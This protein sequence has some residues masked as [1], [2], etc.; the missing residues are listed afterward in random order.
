[1]PADI[2]IF[3]KVALDRLSSPDQID[4]L[5]NVTSSR[6]WLALVAVSSLLA[7]ATAWG[8][9]GSVTTKVDGQG[10]VIRSGGV[11]DIVSLGAGQVIEVRAITGGHVHTGDLIAMVAQPALLDHIHAAE[12]QIHDLEAQQREVASAHASSSR[13]ELASIEQER[14]SAERSIRDLEAEAKLV[15]DEIAVD[16]ELLAKELITRQQVNATEQRLAG[17]ETSAQAK[18]A[19]ITQLDTRRFRAGREGRDDEVGTAN[20]IAAAQRDLDALRRELDQSSKIRSPYTGQVVEV[21]VAAGA[22][23]QAGTPVLSV[24]SE[25]VRLEALIYVPADKAKETKAGMSVEISPASVRREEFG[26][27]RGKV[28]FVSDYPATEAALQRVFENGPLVRALA[29]AGPVTE[30][31]VEMEPDPSTPSGFRWSSAKGAPIQLSGGTLI[32]GEV[33]TREQPPIALVVPFL[34]E[35]LGIR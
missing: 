7:A 13:L 8:Y 23:V 3:R 11:Q 24:Q 21:K 9:I 35:K 30:V 31:H 5:L 14:A 10:V 33:V 6:A 18:R 25:V 19:D 16:Q 29:G 20:R 27:I 34:R 32:A 28:T 15:R 2:R 1:M 22:L 17:L 4:K 12:G 26:F